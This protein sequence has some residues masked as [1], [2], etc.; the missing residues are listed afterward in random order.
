MVGICFY[1]ENSDKDVWSGRKLDAWNYACQAAG[2]IHKIVVIN[3]SDHEPECPG[4]QY[5]FQVVQSSAQAEELMRGHVT[6]VV[7]PWNFDRKDVYDLW[8]YDHITDW[9]AFGPADGWR[10]HVI[11]GGS[12]VTIPMFGSGALHSVHIASAVLMHRYGVLG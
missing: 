4:R 5:D 9:Y 7:C 6:Q 11:E 1:Y 10:G 12:K 8:S 3:L 2:D